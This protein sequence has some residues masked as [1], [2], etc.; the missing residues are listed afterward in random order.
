M[1]KEMYLSKVR[2]QPKRSQNPT[3][4]HITPTMK[5]YST[6]HFCRWGDNLT[7]PSSIYHRRHRSAPDTTLAMS[8]SSGGIADGGRRELQCRWNRVRIHF[9]MLIF[10][11]HLLVICSLPFFLPLMP[12][13]S[14]EEERRAAGGPWTAGGGNCNA[15]E[16]G[17]EFIFFY[18][19]FLLRICLSSPHCPFSLPLIPP[20]S[21]EEERRAVGESH[22]AGGGKYNAA[23]IGWAFYFL[24]THFLLS[25]FFVIW[26][27]PSFPSFNP[28]AQP[29]LRE[30]GSG[31]TVDGGRRGSTLTRE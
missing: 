4:H 25:F 16:I 18:A 31:G 9:H 7:L 15:V 22:I 8:E 2:S 12:L 13:H 29:R 19:Y 27:L 30:G 24:F 10:I 14:V 6:V 17:W 28:S 21:V 11:T 5:N 1:K 20:H 3:P 23:G 26:Y